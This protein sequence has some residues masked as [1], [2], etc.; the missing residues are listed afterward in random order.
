MVNN[1]S[2]TGYQK[3]GE[4][5]VPTSNVPKAEIPEFFLNLADMDLPEAK[6][7]ELVHAYYGKYGAYEREPGVTHGLVV[8]ETVL[9]RNLPEGDDRSIHM[10][11]RTTDRGLSDRPLYQH[12]KRHDPSYADRDRSPSL[13]EQ[14][15]I[16]HYDPNNLMVILT[17]GKRVF[18]VSVNS[19][20]G[21]QDWRSLKRGLG[22]EGL[23]ADLTIDGK[24][25]R[26]LEINQDL[27]SG[28]VNLPGGRAGW[29]LGPDE[30]RIEVAASMP[31]ARDPEWQTKMLGGAAT[32]AT[33]VFVTN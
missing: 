10:I 33:E 22:Y 21:F 32:K 7:Y 8:T 13:V 27:R 24:E 20:V 25:W 26:R 31:D 15:R 1:N 28:V 18:D 4:K 29:I 5:A 12:H 2:L 30:S 23:I 6:V 14:D 17:D 11:V 19:L 3:T 16:N 9:H